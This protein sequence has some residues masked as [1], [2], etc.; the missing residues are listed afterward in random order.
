M[1]LQIHSTRSGE[2]AI[3]DLEGEL[4]LYS[5][6]S[7]SR[8]IEDLVATGCTDITLS[9]GSVSSIDSGGAEAIAAIESRLPAGASLRVEPASDSSR[10]GLIL[11]GLEHLLFAG[12]YGLY[13][14]DPFGLAVSAGYR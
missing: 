7:L 5:A 8:R 10:K 2:Q 14:S 11:A 4:T 13:D 6:Q 9:F 12:G 1:A 3:L